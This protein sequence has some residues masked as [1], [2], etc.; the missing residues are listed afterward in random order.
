MS[1]RALRTVIKQQETQNTLTVQD[2]ESPGVNSEE[3]QPVSGP[4]AAGSCKSAGVHTRAP[5]LT[6]PTWAV[7][8]AVLSSRSSFLQHLLLEER[9]WEQTAG[10][11]VQ[12]RLLDDSKTEGE[13]Y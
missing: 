5:I 6:R 12:L 10:A 9:Q 3:N 8:S 1:L 11:S 13:F 7:R 4:P 2:A